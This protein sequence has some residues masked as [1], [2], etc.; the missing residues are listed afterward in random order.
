MVCHTVGN[1]LAMMC[2]TLT[3]LCRKGVWSSRIAPYCRSHP[4]RGTKKLCQLLHS[5]P[6]AGCAC[7]S[8]SSKNP[9]WPSRCSA[10]TS[11]S[12]NHAVERKY[13]RISGVL[14]P[15]RSRRIIWSMVLILVAPRFVREFAIN[16]FDHLSARCLRGNETID[17]CG[18]Q[19]HTTHRA[20]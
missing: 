8:A 20:P 16:S 1:G 12:N 9:S 10:A 15:S 11:P 13:E 2:K 5:P 17:R 14:E 18:N 4:V 19:A 6:S 7:G 3:P